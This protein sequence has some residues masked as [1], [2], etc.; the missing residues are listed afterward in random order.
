MCVRIYIYL[1]VTRHI[2]THPAMDGHLGRSL[3]LAAVNTAAV[4]LGCVRRFGVLSGYM[5][6]SRVL[7]AAGSPLTQS[8]APFPIPCYSHLQPCRGSDPVSLSERRL[9][10]GQVCLSSHVDSTSC[11]KARRQLMSYF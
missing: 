3:G 11:T 9:G 2:F 10:G 7:F 5:P 4:N 6:R 1:Y 8:P